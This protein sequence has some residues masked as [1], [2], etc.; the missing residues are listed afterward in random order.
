MAQLEIKTALPV[1][2]PLSCVINYASQS[3]NMAGL[4]Q[5]AVRG[6]NTVLNKAIHSLLGG[7]SDDENKPTSFVSGGHYIPSYAIC[8]RS[9]QQ[10]QHPYTA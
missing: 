10:Q 5:S 7:C 1:Q 2:I 9:K 4:R 3:A 6:F 8:G